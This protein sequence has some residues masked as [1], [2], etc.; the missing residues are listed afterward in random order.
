MLNV[1]I[2]KQPNTKNMSCGVLVSWCTDGVHLKSLCCV[3]EIE[4]I[5]YRTKPPRQHDQQNTR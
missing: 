5:R 3:N 4:E 2:H 1:P